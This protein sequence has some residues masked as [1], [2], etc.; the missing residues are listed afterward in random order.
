MGDFR[1][2]YSVALDTECVRQIVCSEGCGSL[3]RALAGASLL[4]VM[5]LG[6]PH[7]ENLDPI[8]RLRRDD[9]NWERH[10]REW[11]RV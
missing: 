1:H 11:A 4:I 7:P 3:N 5:A 6:R 10:H 9:G 2:R 8:S